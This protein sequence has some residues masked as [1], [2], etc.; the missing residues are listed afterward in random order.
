MGG[1]AAPRGRE[2]SRVEGRAITEG[3]SA[4]MGGHY[5]CHGDVQCLGLRLEKGAGGLWKGS[6]NLVCLPCPEPP[7]STQPPT[8][9]LQ[10]T[11]GAPWA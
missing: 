11:V 5:P 2:H 8:Q 7:R 9:R 4:G 1:P 3:C 10:A 6:I